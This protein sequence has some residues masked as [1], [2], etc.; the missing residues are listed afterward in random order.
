MRS[1]LPLIALALLALNACAEDEAPITATPDP[2]AGC[3]ATKLASDQQLDPA[4]GPAVD[5]Q[6]G[7]VS[8]PAGAIVSTTY[9]TLKPDDA[10]YQR[11]G[12]LIDPVIGTL[13]QSPGLLA[14]STG[15]SMACRELRTLTVWES[16]A[17]MMAFVMSDA[18]MAAMMATGEISRGQSRTMSWTAQAGALSWEQAIARFTDHDGPLY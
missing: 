5:P 16:E 3:A 14:V 18:H 8:V 1:A 15:G 17:A 4:Q 9:L 2:F 13:Q 6:T 12:Q 11:F 10:A 7:A